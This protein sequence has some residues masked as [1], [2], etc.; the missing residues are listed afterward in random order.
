MDRHQVPVASKKE[1][2]EG[3]EGFLQEVNV[4][5]PEEAN[6][7]LVDSLVTLFKDKNYLIEHNYTHTPPATPQH[8][9][10]EVL[11]VTVSIITTVLAG[12]K[13]ALTGST[14]TLFN[15]VK[16][17]GNTHSANLLVPNKSNSFESKVQSLETWCPSVLVPVYRIVQSS[18]ASPTWLTT[19]HPL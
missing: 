11:P 6:I 9:Q 2:R 4:V 5:A 13:S 3:G 1:K 12:S 8:H 16:L 17:S 18:A 15:L 10:V 7:D 14:F 19:T